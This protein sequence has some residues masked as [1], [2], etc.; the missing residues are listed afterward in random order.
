MRGTAFDLATF[1]ASV[2]TAFPTLSSALLATYGYL[3]FSTVADNHITN[4]VELAEN[5]LIEQFRRDRPNISAIVN[6]VA[7]MGQDVEDTLWDLSR[8][9]SVSTATG[10]LLD[11]IGDIVGC[12]RTSADDDV[13]RADIYFQIAVNSSSG[14]PEAMIAV[15]QRVTRAL[16]IDYTEFSPATV[17][18][19]VNQPLD[20]VPTNIHQRMERVKP[21][22]VALEVRFTSSERPFV[23]GGEGT[24]P[25]YFSNGAGF[26][27][28][29]A[30][31]TGVGGD[32]TEAIS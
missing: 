31:Y 23:F 19:T 10:A 13:Y 21:G 24:F 30:A 6:S 27:E 28:T 1:G 14:E 4:I 32:F 18:L 5:L 2:R 29:G 26:G 8:F 9:R 12:S 15:L 7:T 11:L 3:R 20:A 25:P 22:G 17:I 16:F